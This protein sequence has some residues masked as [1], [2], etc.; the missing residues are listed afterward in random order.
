MAAA[1][2]F[3]SMDESAPKAAFNRRTIKSNCT[4]RKVS[5]NMN[6]VT[7]TCVCVCVSVCMSVCACVC[8]GVSV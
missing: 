3:S 7:R 5:I 4:E 2:P 6:V 8:L 1:T